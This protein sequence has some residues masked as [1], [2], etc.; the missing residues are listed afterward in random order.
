MIHESIRRAKILGHMIA[1]CFAVGFL[2]PQILAQ[3]DEVW[4]MEE[5]YWRY[6]Q[7]GDVESYLDLWHPDFVGWP[8][9]LVRPT[10]K[11]NVG[12]MVRAVRGQ[13]YRLIVDLHREAVQRFGEIAIVH[14]SAA[15]IRRYANG[16]A[17]TSLF[18]LTHTWKRMESQ[19]QII[20]GMCGPLD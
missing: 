18:K 6:V 17:R 19:W 14:Y 13:E 1:V 8:C 11:A 2:S 3:E 20:G 5:A 7:A 15:T 16:E 4:Q 10:G 9:G 12:S